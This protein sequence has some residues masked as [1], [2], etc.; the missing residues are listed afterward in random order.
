M[1][2]IVKALIERPQVIEE[3]AGREDPRFGWLLDALGDALLSASE[4]LRIQDDLQLQ[5]LR[6]S[7]LATIT[8][9]KWNR[10]LSKTENRTAAS[11]GWWTVMVAGT[12]GGFGLTAPQDGSGAELIALFTGQEKDT[13]V[14][15]YD[16]AL[17]TVSEI[18]GGP[19]CGLSSHGL[20]FEGSCH[21]CLPYEVY[22]MKTHSSGIKCECSHE[23]G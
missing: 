8:A 11:S 12:S 14:L 18:T 16:P 5:R 15:V 23:A 6:E 22:D 13:K 9:P 21:G 10:A 2:R 4:L 7:Y 17:G 1:N 19:H 20:C 3:T